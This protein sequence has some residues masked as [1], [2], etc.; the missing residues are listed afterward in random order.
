MSSLLNVV[1]KENSLGQG[2]NHRKPAVLRRPESVMLLYL[3]TKIKVAGQAPDLR[4]E[5]HDRPGQVVLDIM[6][7]DEVLHTIVRDK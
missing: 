6:V 3:N 5:I 4:L 2:I 7:G 1:E